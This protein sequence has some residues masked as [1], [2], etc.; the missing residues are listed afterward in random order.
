MD[1]GGNT[2]RHHC[3]QAVE[4]SQ[5]LYGF[6]ILG[7]KMKKSILYLHASTIKELDQFV[8][9]KTT[10]EIKF[11]SRNNKRLPVEIDEVITLIRERF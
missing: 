1:A 4:F 10:K 8:N 3:I 11:P 9:Y 6:F 7:G 5:I 2:A